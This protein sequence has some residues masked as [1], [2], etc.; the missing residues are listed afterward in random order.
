MAM[1]NFGKRS[2]MQ[3]MGRLNMHSWWALLF[4]FWRRR[5]RGIFKFF[6]HC[7]QCVSQHVP[8]QVLKVF[9]N[10]FPE[11]C[12]VPKL[13][14]KVFPNAPQFYPIWS[15]QSSTFM[16]INWKG[17]NYKGIHLFLFCNLGSKEMLPLRR[18]QC[19]KIF[20]DGP[21][22]MALLKKFK[23]KK[24]KGYERTHELINMNHI[25]TH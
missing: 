7:S 6:F 3:P 18:A 13:F 16:C 1:N 8:H 10:A 12:Q 19:S 5:W 24:K 21:T 15:A 11:V 9:P 22:N 2:S 17:F 23:K 20:V 4:S 25:I 14:P